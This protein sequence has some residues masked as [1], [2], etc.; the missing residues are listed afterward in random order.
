M[1]QPR[2]TIAR[3]P[4]GSPMKNSPPALPRWTIMPPRMMLASAA[5]PP[6]VQASPALLVLLL[7]LWGARGVLAAGWASPAVV[8]PCSPAISFIFARTWVFLPS[9]SG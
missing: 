5:M 3:I 4:N 7:P 6:I 9:S 1:I 2:N 8:Q